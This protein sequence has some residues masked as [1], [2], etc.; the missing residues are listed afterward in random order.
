[1]AQTAQARQIDNQ[2]IKILNALGFTYTEGSPQDANSYILSNDSLV[3]TDH[4]IGTEKVLANFTLRQL[5]FHSGE[6]GLQ[7][8]E[9]TK[10]ALIDIV[11]NLENN[12]ITLINNAIRKERDDLILRH[13]YLMDMI[14]ACNTANDTYA[15]KIREQI[16]TKFFAQNP[17]DFNAQTAK[18]VLKQQS[19]EDVIAFYNSSIKPIL[20]EKHEFKLKKNSNPFVRLLSPIF[21]EQAFTGV[22]EK[23]L[24]GVLFGFLKSLIKE[25]SNISADAKAAKQN[26]KLSDELR[27]SPIVNAVMETGVITKN[28]TKYI[29]FTKVIQQYQLQAQKICSLPESADKQEQLRI[30]RQLRDAKLTRVAIKAARMLEQQG[31]N[32]RASELM[33]ILIKEAIKRIK[34]EH[35]GNNNTHLKDVDKMLSKLG[36]D[37]DNFDKQKILTLLNARDSASNQGLQARSKLFNRMLKIEASKLVFNE[38]T[39]SKNQFAEDKDYDDTQLNTPNYHKDK[40]RGFKFEV[41]EEV[42]AVVVPPPVVEDEPAHVINN[43]IVAPA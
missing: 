8:G 25:F 6:T 36:I 7:I 24:L 9:N 14:E 31:Q 21:G 18:E 38:Q 17:Q 32:E 34:E 42:P 20:V 15:K 1:M 41:N 5:R 10:Q 35:G 2:S 43:P 37:G 4:Y 13:R 23:G 40:L 27:E 33:N 3:Y 11:A 26:P 28:S 39:G 12:K 22:E 30:A 16:K 29:W 19:S